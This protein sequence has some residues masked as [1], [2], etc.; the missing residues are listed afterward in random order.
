M[1]HACVHVLAHPTGRLI[2]ERNGYAVDLERVIEGAAER[3]CALEL[4]AHPSRLDLD[5]VHV[6]AAK[7]AGVPVAISSD[8]HST[9]GLANIR[10]GVDQARRGWLE[11]ANVLN[12]L[13]WPELK[14]RIRR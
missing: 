3:G 10:F 7:S 9:V 11:P 1:D 13:S 4:N 12:T 2:G 5:D 6:R 8:A 14:S